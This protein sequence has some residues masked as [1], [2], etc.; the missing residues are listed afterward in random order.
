MTTQ[1]KYNMQWVIALIGVL[2]SVVATWVSLN[3]RV[4]AAEVRVEVQ[5]KQFDH[6]RQDVKEVNK[7]LDLLL[8]KV[9]RL[10]K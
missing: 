10:E 9:T 3:T 6:V 5:E 8:E 7:K 2:L 4:A 1:Q